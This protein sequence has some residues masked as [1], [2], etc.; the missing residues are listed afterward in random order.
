M[1]LP[2]DTI[3]IIPARLAATRL[4]NKPLRDIAGK[5]MIERVIKQAVLADCGQIY[6]A[7]PDIEI[8]NHVNQTSAI[9]VMTGEH[10]SGS[11]RIFEALSIIDP[12]R[13]VKYV[14]NLQGDLPNI[15]P[16]SLNA[17][18]DTLKSTNSDIATL[19]TVIKDKKQITDPNSVKI[20]L[21]EDSMHALYFSRAAIP[22]NADRY[23][24]HI[25]VY[26]YRRKALE[27]FVSLNQSK[28]EKLEKLEQLRAL[29]AGMTIAVK[30]IDEI[31]ISVDT[32][33]D[34]AK[35]IHIIEKNN[36]FA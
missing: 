4:P 1:Q 33:Y 25:G 7:T 3:I 31:P 6:V 24:Y 19:G 8:Y 5:T 26:G 28:L 32:E 2:S 30:L 17:L 9:A 27:K 20:V 35:A 22:H 11:D 18:I 15:N 16:T 14:I 36:K 10:E 12:D 21:A 23:Y 34:L 29:E 13:H